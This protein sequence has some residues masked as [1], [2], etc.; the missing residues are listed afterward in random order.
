MES[1]V[2]SEILKKNEPLLSRHLVLSRTVLDKLYEHG[3]LVD[4]MRR[5]IM[6]HPAD[7]QVELLLR[8]IEQRGLSSLRKFLEVLKETGHGYLVDAILDTEAIPVSDLH[9]PNSTGPGEDYGNPGPA[10]H[11]SGPGHMASL[12]SLLRM[13]Q[14]QEQTTSRGGVLPR[15]MLTDPVA[16]GY[17]GGAGPIHPYHSPPSYPT[18]KEIVPST[19]YNLEQVFN[20]QQKENEQAMVV[21][22]QEELAIKQLMEQNARDQQKVRRKQFTV[23]DISKRLAD[24]NAR[25]SEIYDPTPHPSM[26]RYR[27]AQLNQIPWSTDQ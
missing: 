25:A 26:S 20:K 16:V 11:R 10:N 15:T 14:E 6:M 7:R 22:R 23:N 4:Y 19:L 3:L 18:N 17:P 27:L 1:K 13:R 21:L 8:T 9:A 24:I 12:N 2:V 5:K